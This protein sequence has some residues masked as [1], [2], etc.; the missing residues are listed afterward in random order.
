MHSCMLYDPLSRELASLTAAQPKVRKPD[1]LGPKAAWPVA[2][3]T[4]V[5]F[6]EQT[7]YR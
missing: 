6:A 1:M 5:D 4:I 2:A 3:S 7:E